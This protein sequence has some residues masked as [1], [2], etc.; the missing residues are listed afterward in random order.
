MELVKPEPLVIGGRAHYTLTSY[1]PVSI[2]IE[3]HRITDEDVSS[4][5]Q[6]AIMQAGGGPERLNDDA[7]VRDKFEGIA[8]SS[9]ELRTVVRAQLE[10]TNELMMEEQKIG[11]CANAL[12]NRLVQRVPRDQIERTRE[13]VAQSFYMSLAQ[14]DMT[15]AEFLSSSGMSA[16]DLQLMLDEQAKTTAEHEAAISAWAEHFNLQVNDDEVSDFLGV[17]PSE[18]DRFA[19]DYTA[20]P[21]AKKDELRAMAVQNKAMASI[22]SEC[23]CTY[24]YDT[25]SIDK[26]P[27]LKLV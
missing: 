13:F 4:A 14:E 17:P 11:A 15:E 25:P 26:R 7:W 3:A 6:F 23:S 8:R 1:E 12:A 9:S 19:N 2:E 21:M 20:I 10:E 18:K 22:V 5:M 27:H 16:K 24:A